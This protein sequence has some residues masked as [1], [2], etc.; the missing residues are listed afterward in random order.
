MAQVCEDRG[1]QLTPG[2][3]A[4]ALRLWEAVCKG[5]VVCVGPPSA[6]KTTLI[7]VYNNFIEKDHGTA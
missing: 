2:V 7:Q 6:C 1:W 5:P 4:V 3:Q